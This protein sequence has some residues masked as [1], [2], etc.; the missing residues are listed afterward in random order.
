MSPWLVELC[1]YDGPRAADCASLPLL[2]SAN[3]LNASVFGFTTDL[4]L[5]CPSFGRHLDHRLSLLPLARRYR[6]RVRAQRLVLGYPTEYLHPKDSR[7]VLALPRS[8]LSRSSFPLKCGRPHRST[9]SCSDSWLLCNVRCL[10]RTRLV[11]AFSDH[12]HG[13]RRWNPLGRGK[14]NRPPIL[15]TKSRSPCHTHGFYHL[16]HYR[17]YRV[18]IFTLHISCV[19]S[20]SDTNLLEVR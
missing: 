17:G 4:S 5:C 20:I 18:F 1:G 6:G 7:L 2:T 8:S 9:L 19:S 10:G 13:V 11:W 16:A 3:R 12:S 15:S 14:Q